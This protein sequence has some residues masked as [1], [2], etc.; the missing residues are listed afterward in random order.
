MSSPSPASSSEEKTLL[1]LRPA[2]ANRVI[3][4][5]ATRSELPL[6]FAERAVVRFGWLALGYAVTQ[7]L[8][9]LMGAYVQPGWMDPRHAPALY[10]G[11]VLGSALL[12]VIFCALAW[13]QRIPAFRMLDWALVFAV[14]GAL[15]IGLAE[16][17]A[18]WP[19]NM[20]IRGISSLAVWI[21]LF[22]LTVPSTIGKGLV[23]AVV[24][25]LMGPV[26]LV[27]NIMADHVEVPVTSQWLTLFGPTLGMAVSAVV[28]ARF[29]YQLGN[30]VG[31]LQ[32]LGSYQLVER[33]GVGGMGEVWVAKH[34]M[35]ARRVAVKLIK[36]Q[37]IQGAYPKEV[38]AVR[39]RFER[40]AQAIASLNSPHTVELYDFG[41]AEDGTFYYVMELL[42]GIDLHKL[43]REYGPLPAARVIPI[44]RQVCDSLGEA[45]RKG[46][47]HRDVKPANIFLS[48][49]GCR[50]DFAKVL[51]F[52]LAKP[53]Q[54]AEGAHL[55]M[56]GTTLGTPA[57][58]APEMAAGK[59]NVDGQADIYSLGCV[60]YFLLTGSLLFPGKE[61]I[62]MAVSHVRDIPIPPSQRTEL[63]IPE[64]LE[65]L[66]LQCL[67]KDPAERPA[68]CLEVARRLE[69]CVVEQPWDE[70]AAT[71]WWETNRP[72]TVQRRQASAATPNFE[73][74]MTTV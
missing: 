25:A 20:P 70:A 59:T 63:A 65:R 50:H 74:G 1:N 44:L 62:A 46:L 18:S 61:G 31:K 35:L 7:G 26:G 37:S 32:D 11:S 52:G 38:R 12:G 66:V 30:Q 5:A 48:M 29:V 42:E 21:I 28:I 51:D 34:S 24:A 53:I 13:S 23:V 10:N 41:A 72:A 15:G 22:V 47:V 2:S 40:E 3:R 14:L 9:F 8:V 68:G 71:A 64:E 56:S 49:Q 54:E 69:A 60:A 45:H 4:A 36:P 43:V 55:T 57:F 67:S 19:P 27:V 6:D 58:M 39:I 17:A 73:S 16:N 33:I